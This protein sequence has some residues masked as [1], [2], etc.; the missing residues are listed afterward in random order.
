MD[1]QLGKS[2]FW[3]A[4]W[5]QYALSP[6]V[7]LCRVPELEFAS[8]LSL[9]GNVLDHCC[10]DGFFAS[11]AWPGKIVTAGCDIR[12]AAIE[13]ARSRAIYSR[14]DVC[15]AAKHLPYE[16]GMFGLVFS[17]S[18]LE[19]ISDLDSALAE[20]ARVLRPDGI[21]AFNVLNHR[22]FEWWPLGEPA[23]A[24]Y[25]K[26]QPFIHALNLEQWREC[27]GRVGLQIISIEGYLD[28]KAARELAMLDYKFSGTYLAGRHS[29]LVW[30]YRVFWPLLIPYWRRRLSLLRWRTEP[31]A[32]VGYSFKAARTNG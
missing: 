31:D 17:N 21:F 5:R 32:G 1:D 12:R 4:L 2:K 14:C 22:Y 18:A 11:L 26:W 30:S 13:K 16:D 8:R 20:I 25:R 9:K 23:K 27:L 15:D 7:S 29:V 28:R 3:D 6:S 24:S 10:G 19:H